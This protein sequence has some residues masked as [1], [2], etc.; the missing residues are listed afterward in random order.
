MPVPDTVRIGKRG[1]VVIPQAIRERL[2]LQEGDRLRLAVVSGELR[3]RPAVESSLAALRGRL[4]GAPAEQPGGQRA[5][6]SPGRE[7]FERAV[8]AEEAGRYG[9]EPPANRG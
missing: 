2:G 6:A 3:L 9:E 7:W 1:T 5:D 4:A 8:A